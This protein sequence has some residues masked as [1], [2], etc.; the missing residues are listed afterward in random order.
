MKLAEK[1]KTKIGVRILEKKSGNQKRI[2]TICNIQHAKS[3][4]L[5][6]NATE[7]V[8]F[9]I[10]KD[11]AKK[12]SQH[13]N[14][15]ILGYVNSKKLI[16]H[17]LYR[18]GFDFFSRNDLNWYYKPVSEVTDVFV[19]KEFDIL[20]DLSLEKYYPIQYIV[21]LSPAKFKVGI[22]SQNEK[23]LDLMIDIEKENEQMKKVHEE[24]LKDRKKKISSN[25]IEQ[26]VEKKT[27]TELQL[28]FLINQIM[29][30]LTILKKN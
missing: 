11:F 10:I 28:S 26:A 14:V 19:K 29:H 3:I 6:Y 16:D 8:S 17:Y 4:G 1:I 21:A 25:E 13:S 15:S 5:I 20:I 23:H 7:F 24:I 27:Q 22:F 9:E 30:Y 2:V 18:K 12:L